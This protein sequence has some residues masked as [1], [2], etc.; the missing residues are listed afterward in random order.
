MDTIKEK[1]KI[2]LALVVAITIGYGLGYFYSPSKIKEVEKVVEKEKK[3]TEENKKVT[4]KFDPN[5]GKLT[6]R[7]EETEKKETETNTKKSDKETEKQQNKKMWAAKAGGVVNPRDLEHSIVP[8]V[9]A[10]VRLPIFDSWIG[11]EADI[12]VNRPLLGLYLRVE[13]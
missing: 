8:R 12:S 9:G 4:E 5:T 7:I 1:L 10:E 11:A 3:T 13:F 2:F 6:E